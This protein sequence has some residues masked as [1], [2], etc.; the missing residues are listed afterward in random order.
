MLRALPVAVLVAGASAKTY[1]LL[2]YTGGTSF[3]DSWVYPGTYDTA[4][5]APTPDSTNSGDDWLGTPPRAAL[6]SSC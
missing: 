3:F 6:A 1:N 5:N 4:N 2:R